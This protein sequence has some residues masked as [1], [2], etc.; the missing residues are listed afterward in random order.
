M[1]VIALGNLSG[2]T[3]EKSKGEEFT[4]DTKTGAELVNRGV[5]REVVESPV[6]KTA[7]VAKE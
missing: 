6:A 5:V 4:V 3:G 1:K 7:E 2:A